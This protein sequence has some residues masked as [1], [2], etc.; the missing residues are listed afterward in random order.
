MSTTHHPTSETLNAF[1]QGRLDVGRH[2]VV[3][4]HLEICPSCQR[5]ARALEHAGGAHLEH[6]QGTPLEGVALERIM[7]RLGEPA[8]ERHVAPLNS[9][10]DLPIA[11]RALEPY[12]LGAW[13][14]IGPGVHWR[15]VSVP[16]EGGARVFLLRASA[17]THLPNHTHTGTE[18]TLILKGAFAHSGGRFGVGDFDEADGSVEH[19]PIVEPGEDCVCLVAMEGQLRLLGLAGRILQPFV[20]M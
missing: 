12:A 19:Q 5:L 6:L 9:H 20:R 15:S 1:W 3:A 7:A 11:L 14:W 17:G 2:V 8:A 18:L 13:R 4:A 16:A 10:P